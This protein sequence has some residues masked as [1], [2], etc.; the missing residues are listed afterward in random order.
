[1]TL[2]LF[3][4]FYASDSKRIIYPLIFIELETP[5][6]LALYKETNKI[7]GYV[8]YSNI[9]DNNMFIEFIEVNPEYKN[10]NLCKRMLSFLITQKPE[11]I[12]YELLNVGGLV[13][14][15]YY[16]DAFESNNF[17]VKNKF[18]KKI[19]KENLNNMKF[20]KI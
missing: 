12:T 16:V 1:M 11:I 2:I 6:V 4:H 15:N 10:L 18:D 3:I 20:Y 7:I 5:M 14:Y 13:G 9:E 8:N 19:K 17:N